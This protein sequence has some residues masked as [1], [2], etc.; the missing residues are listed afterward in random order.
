LR[1]IAILIIADSSSSSK[2]KFVKDK[3][4][5]AR[6]GGDDIGLARFGGDD[7]G[8]LGEVG[9]FAF[10][11]VFGDDVIFGDVGVL[12][13]LLRLREELGDIS[14]EELL[15]NF[16][17]TLGLGPESLAALGE[18]GLDEPLGEVPRGDEVF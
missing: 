5:A 17:L 3:E 1:S 6:F 2:L 7:I 12:G 13:L 11:G 10:I 16:V 9:V 8:L 4:F 14:D 18:I 15:L